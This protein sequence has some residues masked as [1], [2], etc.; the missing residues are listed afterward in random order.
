M[1]NFISNESSRTL[2]KRLEEL[3]SASQELKFLVGF[4]YFSGIRELCESLKASPEVGLKVLV[5]LEADQSLGTLVEYGLSE[6]ESDALGADRFFSSVRAAVNTAEFDTAEFQ[7]QAAFFLKLIREERLI[8]RKTLKPSH[9]KLYIFKLKEEH[10]LLREKLFI[11]GSSN[12]TRAGLVDQQEF[13][14]EIGDYGS[15]EAEAFF[16]AL[17]LDAICIT[18]IPEFR[19]KLLKLFEEETLVSEITP[20]EAY[21]LILKTYAD[22]QHE[23]EVEPSA[24]ELLEQKG[25]TPYAYQLDAVRQALSILDVHNGVIIADVVGLG[26]SVI[27]SLVAKSLKKRGLII[28][29][30]G[31]VGDKNH[32]S[33][34]RK[35]VSDFSL[36]RWEVRSC[37]E[38]ESI[39]DFVRNQGKDCEVVVI[40]EAHRFRNQDSRHYELLSRICR[41]RKVILLTATPF[42]NSPGDIFSLLKLFTVP[43]KSTLTL[44]DDLDGRFT[45]YRTTFT[46]LSYIRKNWNSKE[47]GK[48]LRAETH[49]RILFDDPEVNL[50][51]VE[52]RIRRLSREIRSV[53][54]PVTIRRNRLDLRKDPEYR[55]E[56]KE[57]PEVRE[58]EEQF[59]ELSPEQSRFYDRVMTD[60]F[61]EEG[62]FTGAIYQPYLYETGVQQEGTLDEEG[63]RQ[64]QTQRNLF[65]FMRRLLVKRF[66]SSFEAFEKSIGSFLRV[67]EKAEKFINTSGK[68]ILDRDLLNDVFEK[69]E[70]EI[71]AA[72]EAFEKKMDAEKDERTKRDQVY[73]LS[74]FT[75]AE[76]FKANI[77]SDIE[78]LKEIQQEVK[79]LELTSHDPKTAELIKALRRILK[80]KPKAGEPRRKVIVFSEYV[81]TVKYLRPAL[82][83]AFDGRVFTVP[84]E[85][86]VHK[87]REMLHNFDAFAPEDKMVDDYDILLASDK[88]SEGF[89]LNRAG[90]IVNYDIPWN[91]TRVI[92]RVGRIN[93]I[94]KKVFDEL[95]ICNFFPTEQGA[96]VVKS[97]QIAADKM[98]MIHRTLGEDAQIFS[99]DEEPT[100]SALYSRVSRAP[101]EEGGESSF[102]EIRRLLAEIEKAHPEVLEKIKK[103][104]PRIK[105]G[106]AAAENSLV[107]FT[108]KGRD[109]FA[110]ARRDG[111]KEEI[112]ELSVEEAIGLI[113]CEFDEPRISFSDAFWENYIAVRDYREKHPHATSEISIEKKALNVVNAFKGPEFTDLH[114]FILTLREDMLEYR[115]LPVNTLRRIAD[116]GKNKERA[117]KEF[118]DLR[119]E[120]GDDYLKQLKTRVKE[121][122]EEVIIAVENRAGDA[123]HG[124]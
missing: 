88:I 76:Q 119:A 64:Y 71:N 115:T 72:L 3:I 96:D 70:D 112:A 45:E 111:E 123:P 10:K 95:F 28:C 80:Q 117:R 120:L 49:Y 8:I 7:E 39:A 17:W 116:I 101:E 107:V 89:N 40:D 97:R 34:W 25:Y 79:A 92:Q 15:D 30:P 85:L 59:F 69:D 65:E 104:A 9:A 46:R 41:N 66:E 110:Q 55:K 60:Y 11:T 47:D 78:L 108:K 54:E 67:A 86:G 14:V 36:E 114:P 68:Y 48:R 18:E 94:G 21:A 109:L 84:G 103:F 61:G 29:P 35:Y 26:K 113:R 105:T 31:L 73:V 4:F 93:R 5:G 44:T 124:S 42:N 20:F 32:E 58:P 100:A 102:T 63:N 57:L 118:A 87:E 52:N 91:P 23:K 62:R 37:G 56:I 24:V 121:L 106:K 75:D 122:R 16:D 33:G 27:A 1:Q 6:P 74:R 82:E 51:L 38:L 2:K 19:T 77:R 13:N 22:L 50:S 43:G 98:F 81:D 53:I 12:L 83:E 99:A 90:A